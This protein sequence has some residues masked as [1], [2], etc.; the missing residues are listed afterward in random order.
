MVTI[1]YCN[2]GK[3]ISDFGF[4][5]YLIPIML[6]SQRTD[7]DITYK[8]STSI[9]FR[10]IQIGILQGAIDYKNIQIK[11][12]GETFKLDKY[13]TSNNWPEGCADIYSR[14]SEEF[15][16]LMISKRRVKD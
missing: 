14:L 15:L 13:G 4:H 1:E 2:D 8:F 9:P 3:P 10:K 7:I 16:K 5:K 12:R 11:F 6:N